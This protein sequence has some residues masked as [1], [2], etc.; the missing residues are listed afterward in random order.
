LLAFAYPMRWLLARMSQAD[1]GSD[2][3]LCFGFHVRATRTSG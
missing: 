2:Q 1:R 3:L